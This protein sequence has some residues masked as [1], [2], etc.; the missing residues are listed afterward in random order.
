MKIEEEPQGEI[1]T[2]VDYDRPNVKREEYAVLYDVLD[3]TTDR[4]FVTQT[5]MPDSYQYSEDYSYI[6]PMEQDPIFEDLM[7]LE[8]NFYFYE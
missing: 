6:R 8:P 5:D 1:P 4:I 7:N 3:L 2:S